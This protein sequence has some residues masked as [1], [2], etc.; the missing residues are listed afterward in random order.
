M[1]QGQLKI[2]LHF[3]YLS[4]LFVLLVSWWW[5]IL[6]TASRSRGPALN[7][8]KC[9]NLLLKYSIYALWKDTNYSRDHQFLGAKGKKKKIQC[10]K[11]HHHPVFETVAS[12]GNLEH[13]GSVGEH[14]RLVSV[15]VR[16]W[17]DTRQELRSQVHRLRGIPAKSHDTHV[18]QTKKTLCETRR[19]EGPGSVTLCLSNWPIKYR[20]QRVICWTCWAKSTTLANI[21]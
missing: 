9:M 11:T 8:K 15:G 7:S 17:A 16:V 19:D 13:C 18:S 14:L 20:C 21:S 4:I 2:C 1:G 12:A 5:P 3:A 6:K 10:S